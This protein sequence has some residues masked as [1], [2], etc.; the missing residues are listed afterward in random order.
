MRKTLELLKKLLELTHRDKEVEINKVLISIGI[1]N[2]LESILEIFKEDELIEDYDKQEGKLKV[3][4]ENRL[5]MA[6]KAIQLGGDVEGICKKLDWKEFE[7]FVSKI[8]EVR[9]YNVSKHYR[10]KHKNRKYEIDILAYND[11]FILCIDC[12]HWKYG[13]QKSKLLKAAKMQLNRAITFSKLDKELKFIKKEKK[14]RIFPIV[15][16]LMDVPFKEL[17]KVPIVPI[18]KFNDFIYRLSP[19]IDEFVKITIE[20]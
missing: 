13:W 3:S 17:V 19:T 5:K 15:L 2:D 1:K 14:L 8:L 4:F 10:F 16:T 18:L 7:N 11:L 9:G 12:K 20:S 6:I